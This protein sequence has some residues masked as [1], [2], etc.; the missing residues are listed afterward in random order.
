MVCLLLG[1]GAQMISAQKKGQPVSSMNEMEKQKAAADREIKETKAELGANEKKV[2]ESLAA[3]RKI[4][5]EIATSQAE[6]ETVQGQLEMINR[7]ISSL[8]SSIAKEEKEL[9]GLRE[10]YLKAVKKMRVARKQG[11]GLTFLFAS[12]NFNEAR[13]RMRYM[14]EFS[15]WKNRRSSEITDK[16]NLLE[17]QKGQLVQARNDASVALGREMA[18]KEKLSHQ[19][20]E[21]QTRV[22]ELRANSETLRGKLAKRQAESRQLSN[23]ISA[24]I[25]E[26]RA[27]EAREAEARRKAAE[28]KRMAEEKA[29]AEKKAAEE[30]RLA[31]EKARKEAETKKTE[32]AS[33][34][35]KSKPKQ[36]TQPK[37]ENPKQE[38][39]KQE[40][41]KQG[42]KPKQEKAS[43]SEYAEARKRQPRSSAS[44]ATTAEATPVETGFG[45]MKGKLPRPVGGAFTIVSPFGVHPISP[46]LPDIMDENLGIDAHVAN[47]ATAQAVYEGEV[48]K[49]YDRTSIPGFR[50]ILVL[51]H[52]DYITV[53]AN[54]DTLSVR[55]GQHVQ[56]GQSLG[57]VGTDFDDSAHGLIHFEV[58]KN[59]THLDPAAW[60][61]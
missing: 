41:P 61:R 57:T 27:K 18:A 42:S 50:N 17:T 5:A 8:E 31:E 2:N 52:G 51:K 25:A 37:Q 16:V 36:E 54:L 6:I 39:T 30:K 1:A 15:E 13:R 9:A 47:G 49:I 60:I 20:S 48:L 7:N 14:K 59:Q 55:T 32:T 40:K 44:S 10:E 53:Y 28:E 34:T 11:S 58:W 26:Q 22:S 19:Q 56:Q 29:A 43:G 35:E 45:A 21:Q 46:E 24:L 12:K 4:E 33:K 23:Q 3:L 38:K